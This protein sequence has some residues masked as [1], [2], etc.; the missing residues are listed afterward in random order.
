MSQPFWITNVMASVYIAFWVSETLH[1]WQKAKAREWQGEDAILPLSDL[2]YSATKKYL[3]Y[4]KLFS[5][6][7]HMT[8]LTC[9][10]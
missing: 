8:S 9:E 5:L 1:G 3:C 2:K 6:K 4:Q 10:I 7:Y